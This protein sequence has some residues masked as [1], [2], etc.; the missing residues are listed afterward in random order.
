V[1]GR[2]TEARSPSSVVE[3]LIQLRAATD[4][5]ELAITTITHEHEDRVRSYQLLAKEW[6]AE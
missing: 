4:A 3:Q 6:F 2:P 5:D 1:S